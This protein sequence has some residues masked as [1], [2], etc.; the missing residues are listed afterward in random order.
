MAHFKLFYQT[1]HGNHLLTHYN[2]DQ[3]LIIGNTFDEQLTRSVDGDSLK[4][5]MLKV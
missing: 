5:S 4:F 3:G 2:S 1:Q